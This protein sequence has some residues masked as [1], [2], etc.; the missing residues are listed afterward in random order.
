MQP[1]CDEKPKSPQVNLVNPV[2]WFANN[3]NN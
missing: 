2:E 1:V 3:K